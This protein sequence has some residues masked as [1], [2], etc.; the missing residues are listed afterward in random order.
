MQIQTTRFGTL[1]LPEEE[2]IRFPQPL[3]GLE[4]SQ[5]YCLVRHNDG[6]PFLWLQSADS[7]RTAMVVTDPFLFFP[8]YE[9]E[10]PDPAAAALQAAAPGDVEIYSTVNVASDGT[11]V[12]ANLLGPIVINRQARVG[13]QLVLDAQKYTTRHPIAGPLSPQTSG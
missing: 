5:R 11:G 12:T 6:G 9:V 3:Y 10:I 7:P 8:A 13:V 1:D 4:Q 2:L